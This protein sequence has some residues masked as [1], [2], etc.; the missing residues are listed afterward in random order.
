MR[1]ESSSRGLNCPSSILRWA[2][3]RCPITIHFGGCGA[4]YR[5]ART[6]SGV[7]DGCTTELD[8]AY[9]L[10][11]RFN[12]NVRVV[13]LD[14]SPEE[15]GTNVPTEVALVGGGKAV[16]GQLNRAWITGNGSTL[17]KLRGGP[18]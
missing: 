9:G 7:P 10:P 12:E 8:H 4:Q 17:R 2:K 11:P 18:H 13:Q 5:A 1:S 3:V 15:I 14:I 16:V 6:R